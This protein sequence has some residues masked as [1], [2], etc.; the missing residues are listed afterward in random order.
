VTSDVGDSS[1]GIASTDD[2]V[3]NNNTGITLTVTQSGDIVSVDYTANE[4]G[5]NGT[6]TYSIT[7]L[8]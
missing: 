3:E 2:Y 6:M 8:A 4:Q 1:T 7:H 5:V